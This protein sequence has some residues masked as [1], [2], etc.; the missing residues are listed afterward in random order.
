MNKQKSWPIDEFASFELKEDKQKQEFTII[1]KGNLK[2]SDLLAFKVGEVEIT[3][4]D[5]KEYVE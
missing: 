1:L 5:I 4:E 3:E 2:Y